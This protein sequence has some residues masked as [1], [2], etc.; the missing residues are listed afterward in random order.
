MA[1]TRGNLAVKEKTAERGLQSPRYR[2]TTKVVTRRSPL[3]VKEKLL[4]LVTILFC[5]GVMGGLLWQNANLYNIKRQMYNLDAEMQ[6]IT[7]EVKELSVQ[8]EK[9]EEEIPEKAA[10]LGYV[11]QQE[12]FHIQVPSNSQANGSVDEVTTAKK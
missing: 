3:P 2:E 9:L 11:E 4:Y 8:K 1:Y 6:A 7:V 5:V 12:G 10:A